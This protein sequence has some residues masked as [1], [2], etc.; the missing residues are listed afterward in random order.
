M[1]V[2]FLDNLTKFLQSQV[3]KE[4]NFHH[5]ISVV[6]NHMHAPNWVTYLTPVYKE[7]ADAP[8]LANDKDTD[9]LHMNHALNF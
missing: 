2:L 7:V 8:F 1:K 3:V 9:F 6:K 4:E 5:L